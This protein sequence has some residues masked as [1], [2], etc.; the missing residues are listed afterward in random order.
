[1]PD[2]LPK[3]EIRIKGFLDQRYNRWF[4][5]MEMTLLPDGETCLCGHLDPP[6]L[7]GVLNRIRDLNLPL[8]LVQQITDPEQE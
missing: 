6:A 3:Y 8:I 7:H 4:A 5:G 1:M 2:R